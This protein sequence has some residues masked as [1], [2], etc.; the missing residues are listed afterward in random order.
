MATEIA[1]AQTASEAPQ[2]KL[3][4]VRYRPTVL[5]DPVEEDGETISVYWY[6]EVAED[7]ALELDPFSR[8]RYTNLPTFKRRAIWG[9]SISISFMLSFAFVFLGGI[10]TGN[11]TV[12]TLWDKSLIAAGIVCW[13]FAGIIGWL[14]TRWLRNRELSVLMRSKEDPG[15]K[16]YRLEPQT[17]REVLDKQGAFKATTG[18]VSDIGQQWEIRELMRRSDHVSNPLK[19]FGYLLMGGGGLAFFIFLIYAL[20]AD[21]K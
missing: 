10:W 14:F 20:G 11:G 7:V 5:I 4:G 21:A 3:E 16:E 6:G 13:P 17:P 15:D 2:Q 9:F 12:F 19:N 18:V 1:Q 8:A